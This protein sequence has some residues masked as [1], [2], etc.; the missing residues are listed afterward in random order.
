MA[1]E[2]AVAVV[3]IQSEILARARVL[4]GEEKRL[5]LVRATPRRPIERT[6]IGDCVLAECGDAGKV[7]ARFSAPSW[8]KLYALMKDAREPS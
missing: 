3:G 2:R 5:V 7:H 1:T 4:L 6:A 8:R